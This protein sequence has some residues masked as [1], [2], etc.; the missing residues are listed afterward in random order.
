MTA[1]PERKGLIFQAH[2]TLAVQKWSG[3]LFAKQGANVTV[4]LIVQLPP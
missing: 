3:L 1:L 2:I 4:T